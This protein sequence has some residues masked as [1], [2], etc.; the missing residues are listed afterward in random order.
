[1]PLDPETTET[2]SSFLERKRLQWETLAAPYGVQMIQ[3]GERGTQVCIA[4]N[5]GNV[6]ESVVIGQWPHTHVHHGGS[7]RNPARRPALDH[8]KPIE[9]RRIDM[10]DDEVKA[11]IVGWL[12]GKSVV[13]MPGALMVYRNGKLS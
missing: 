2:V 4:F 13:G 5:V 9:K 12:L 8:E 1:M 10:T 3:S 6:H 11:V 7:A